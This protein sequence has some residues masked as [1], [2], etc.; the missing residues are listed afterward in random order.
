MDQS[1]HCSLPTAGFGNS[2]AT[3][4]FQLLIA[5]YCGISSPDTWPEDYGE[6]LI[7]TNDVEYDF[8]IVGA[9][10]AGS[11]VANR[12]SRID[13][14]R[15]LILEAGGDPPVESE[16]PTLWPKTLG[17]KYTWNYSTEPSMDYSTAYKNNTNE[18]PRGKLLGGSGGVNA[19]MYIS[20]YG[21][22]EEFRAWDYDNSKGWS[23]ED[24]RSYF[25]KSRSFVD[26]AGL[27]LN[28]PNIPLALNNIVLKS[29]SELGYNLV[30]QQFRKG[31]T[32]TFNFDDYKGEG[33]TYQLATVLNGR[34]MS[35]GK[36]YLAA[37]RSR[38]NLKVIKQA[39]V[40][41]INMKGNH[42]QSVTFVYK[43]GDEVTVKAHKEIILSAGALNTPQLLLLS[44]VGPR[45]HLKKLN[46][47]LKQELPVGHNLQD[48]IIIPMYF[49]LKNSKTKLTPGKYQDE[50]DLLNYIYHRK[51]PLSSPKESL[52]ALI[53]TNPLSNISFPDIAFFYSQTTKSYINFGLKHGIEPLNVKESDDILKVLVLLIH[54][55]SRG[56]VELKT[57]NFEDNPRIVPNYYNIS[58]DLETLVRGL[59]FQLNFENTI[60]FL[61][62]DGKFVDLN[63]PDCKS[64]KIKSD[65]YLRCYIRS[66]TTSM[67]HPVGTT[68]MGDD[69]DAVVDHQLKVK[70]VK[71]LRV[72]DNS[73]IP[74]T[75]IPNI[76]AAAAM[77][78]EKGSDLIISDWKQTNK[79]EL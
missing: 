49:K 10:T 58:S 9:G 12:L 54:P 47:P 69:L 71:G 62:L 18:W 66:M 61:E 42:A 6:E 30:D 52:A 14:W 79:N 65:E 59:R 35:T 45:E 60:P 64:L 3:S 32:Y 33:F 26:D 37:V 25:V 77:I 67:S 19:M 31:I 63:L 27:I 23:W 73:I 56:Y 5:S 40:K 51:G 24:V 7:E 17:T 75:I 2:V 1:L 36:T 15:V 20:G 74:T 70:G 28:Y 41:K 76:N 4:L 46:I 55:L 34:R 21:Y 39:H 44:G 68:K 13:Q 11:V 16:I 8:I 50:E 78:G 53:N 48:H 43:N 57:T 38:T 29:G 22:D 72:I